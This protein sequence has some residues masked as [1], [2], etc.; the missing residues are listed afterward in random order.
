[1]AGRCL[2][3][4]SLLVIVIYDNELLSLAPAR[5]E[6]QQKLV[7]KN[8]LDGSLERFSGCGAM[9]PAVYECGMCM[10]AGRC[11]QSN[12]SAAVRASSLNDALSL[13]G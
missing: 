8:K 5:I 6:R 9:A 2:L 4:R 7:V 1:M 10:E 3:A 12:M 13:V 11:R